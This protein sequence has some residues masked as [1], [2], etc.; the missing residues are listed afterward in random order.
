M[1]AVRA[2]PSTPTVEEETMAKTSVAPNATER[3]KPANDPLD[4]DEVMYQLDRARA[5]HFLL[6]ELLYGNLST[7]KAGRPVIRGE[8]VVY[9]R[10][11]KNEKEIG[12]WLISMA[13]A[14]L[15]RALD[16]AESEYRTK[17]GKAVA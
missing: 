8:K 12:G 5:T 7:L 15:E 9:R 10:A 17:Y 11:S 13:V 2:G 4:T 6:D 3:K 14:E 16:D 1:N